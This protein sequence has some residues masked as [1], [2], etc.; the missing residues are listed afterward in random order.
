MMPRD[1]DVVAGLAAIEAFR[2]E[3]LG[4]PYRAHRAEL[5]EWEAARSAVAAELLG[6]P[7]AEVTPFMVG[8]VAGLHGRPDLLEGRPVWKTPKKRRT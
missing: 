2:E 6:V 5:A 8:V 4:D 3:L 1:P 7:V